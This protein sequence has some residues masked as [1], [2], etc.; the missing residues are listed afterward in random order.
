MDKA[1]RIYKGNAFFDDVVM[2][3]F[4]DKVSDAQTMNEDVV[5]LY[6]NEQ[7]IGVNIFDPEFTKTFTP[8]FNYPEQDA[9]NKISDY[10]KIENLQ[11]DKH[12]YLV[13]G[14]VKKVEPIANSEHLQLCDVLVNDTMYS[15]VCGASNVEVDMKT[16]VALDNAILPTGVLIKAGP[17]LK[18]HSD[19]MLCSKCELGMHQRSEEKGIIKL[20]D[21][22]QSGSSFFSIDWRPYNV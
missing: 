8:G 6:H 21:H 1:V 18:T 17:V 12:K 11:Y 9:L 3:E 5:S 19:G 13:V 2:I 7:V 22:E 4:M 15:I 10:L 16:I 20:A 14:H